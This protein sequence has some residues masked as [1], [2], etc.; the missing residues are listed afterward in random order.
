MRRATG[1]VC[2]AWGAIS[3]SI[4]GI[5]LLRLPM[6]IP[7]FLLQRLGGVSI[8]ID[9]VRAPIWAVFFLAVGIILLLWKPKA[10]PSKRV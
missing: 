3:L 1:I 9:P 8:M 2:V 7:G 5:V 10:V 4:C 6:P